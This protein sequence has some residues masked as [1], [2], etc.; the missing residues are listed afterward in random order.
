MLLLSG[1]PLTVVSSVSVLY[2]QAA[3]VWW[4]QG[5]VQG[6]LTASAV[7][8]ALGS[9]LLMWFG[10]VLKPLSPSV[11]LCTSSSPWEEVPGTPA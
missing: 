1:A 8:R 4:E 7:L 9:P 2:Q 11:R 6:L 10:A 3:E 5:E